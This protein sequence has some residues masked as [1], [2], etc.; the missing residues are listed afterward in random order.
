[1][2]LIHKSGVDFDTNQT[3]HSDP[4]CPVDG[5]VVILEKTSR[6]RKEIFL[7][8]QKIHRATEFSIHLSRHLSHLHEYHVNVPGFPR[9]SYYLMSI[10][11]SL[12]IIC[13]VE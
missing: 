13:I 11:K 5:D 6:N 7:I 3:V 1:M 9:Y 10:G 4:S 8:T 12:Q 2:V